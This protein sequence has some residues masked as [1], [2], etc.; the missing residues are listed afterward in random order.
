MST[1]PSITLKDIVRI[2]KQMKGEWYKVNGER[3]GKGKG[4]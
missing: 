3:T 1:T 4:R 2:L